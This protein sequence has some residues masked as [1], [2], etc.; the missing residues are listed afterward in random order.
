MAVFALAVGALFG[1]GLGWLVAR[2]RHLALARALQADQLAIS[3]QLADCRE[4]L[5]ASKAENRSSDDRIGRLLRAGALRA[6]QVTEFERERAR[7]DQEFRQVSLLAARVPTLEA[8]LAQ[9]EMRAAHYDELVC[10]VAQLAPLVDEVDLRDQ[11]IET[12]HR[13]LVHRDERILGLRTGVSVDA[14]TPVGSPVSPSFALAKAEADAAAGDNAGDVAAPAG[15]TDRG[16]AASGS[17][18]ARKALGQALAGLGI[19]SFA[20]VACLDD[21]EQVSPSRNEQ[22]LDAAV[23]RSARSAVVASHGP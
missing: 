4:Q 14:A 8:R 9:A 5:A 10:R 17:F 22:E 6:G 2:R 15:L 19:E 7:Y 21:V 1:V 12:L 13:Q 23:E 16:N 11:Y 18:I 3:A 20:E